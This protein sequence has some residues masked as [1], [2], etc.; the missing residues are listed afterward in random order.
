[1]PCGKKEMH[2]VSLFEVFFLELLQA[3]GSWQLPILGLRV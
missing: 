3:A 1:M 2:A